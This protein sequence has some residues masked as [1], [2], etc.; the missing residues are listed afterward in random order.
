M[1]LKYK[2]RVVKRNDGLWGWSCECGR[3]CH[4]DDYRSLR[5]RAESALSRHSKNEH[6]Y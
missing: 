5:F 1:G 2:S 4:P 3:S 6:G